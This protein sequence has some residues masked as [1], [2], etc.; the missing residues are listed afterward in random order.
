MGLQTFQGW[1]FLDTSK[2]LSPQK[3]LLESLGEHVMCSLPRAWYGSRHFS[4]VM[5]LGDPRVRPLLKGSPV[6]LGFCSVILRVGGE[7]VL[8]G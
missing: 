5:L 2:H 1:I 7:Q 3:A 8:Q 6:S 4:F